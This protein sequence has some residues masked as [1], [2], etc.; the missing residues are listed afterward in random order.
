MMASGF[1]TSSCNRHTF[2]FRFSWFNEKPVQIT[3]YA[4]LIPDAKTSFFDSLSGDLF[5]NNIDPLNFGTD[6]IADNFCTG[7]AIF[8]NFSGIFKGSLLSYFR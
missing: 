6:C 2:F 7:T 3:N 1:Q 4:R 5:Q 8:H